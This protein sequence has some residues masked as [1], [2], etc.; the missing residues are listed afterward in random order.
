[1]TSHVQQGHL[2]LDKLSRAT[3]TVTL[4]PRARSA[5]SQ[6]WPPTSAQPA[7]DSTDRAPAMT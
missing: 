3:R 7:A 2:K 4:T 6:V 1:M 5:P